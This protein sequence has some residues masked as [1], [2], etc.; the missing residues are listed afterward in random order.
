MTTVT[1]I[2]LAVIVAVVLIDLYLKRKNKLATTKEIEKVVDKENPEKPWWKKNWV[3][4]EW[5]KKRITIISSSVLA[6]ALIVVGFIFWP[7]YLFD[8]EDEISFMQNLNMP[9]YSYDEVNYSK[10]V[11]RYDLNMN[12]VNKDFILFR[13]S[14][15]KELNE[16][17]VINGI[18]EGLW[19]AWSGYDGSM[20]KGYYVNGI[21]EGVWKAWY[22]EPSFSNIKSQLKSEGKYI[23]GEKVGL[24]KEWSEFGTLISS[25]VLTSS[26]DKGRIR[27]ADQAEKDRVRQ[28]ERNKKEKLR[29]KL[30]VEYALVRKEIEK[31]TEKIYNIPYKK[32]RSLGNYWYSGYYHW[33][34]E[35]TLI[36]RNEVR[37]HLTNNPVLSFN[38]LKDKKE[39]LSRLS[40]ELEEHLINISKDL[41][42]ILS[43][44]K[45]NRYSDSGDSF[46]IQS[47]TEWGWSPLTKSSSSIEYKYLWEIGYYDDGAFFRCTKHKKRNCWVKTCRC[48]DAQ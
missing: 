30:N 34:F 42:D 35:R 17:I 44:E 32:V 21:K 43:W 48:L 4:P 28:V 41:C 33:S 1:I 40:L 19:R 8:N 20:S 16:G 7:T 3:K 22:V 29:N 15:D 46:R 27:Q 9:R 26:A 45:V 36:L 23:N 14:R 5:N 24:W 13:E 12:K 25:E 2:L 39:H 6:V 10:G 37:D 11:F 47:Y 18:K 31:L 38:K